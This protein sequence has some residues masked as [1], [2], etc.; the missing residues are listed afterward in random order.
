MHVDANVKLN[1]E[2]IREKNPL[3]M[4]NGKKLHGKVN[5]YGKDTYAIWTASVA[6]NIF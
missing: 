1:V 2:C 3:Q 4:T 5:G 6:S